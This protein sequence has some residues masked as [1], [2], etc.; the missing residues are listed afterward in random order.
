MKPTRMVEKV[1]LRTDESGV[2]LVGGTRVP[3]DTVVAAFDRGES[4]EEIALSYDALDLA[5]I[6][7]VLG[8]YLRHRAEVQEHLRKRDAIRA[9]VRRQN[10]ARCSPVGIRERLLARQNGGKGTTTC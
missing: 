3:L 2:V 6:Y 8:Y 7:V 4:A 5:D 10:E 9:E 1:P